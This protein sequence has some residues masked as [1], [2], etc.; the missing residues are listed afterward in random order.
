MSGKTDLNDAQLTYDL[1]NA[2][3]HDFS[4]V[5]ME[6]MLRAD[7]S[8]DKQIDVADVTAIVAIVRK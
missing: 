2:T 6:K 3:Y 1:Y 8:R 7:V 5:S 4:V